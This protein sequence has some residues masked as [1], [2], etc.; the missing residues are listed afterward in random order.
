[1]L[2]ARVTENAIIATTT[3]TTATYSQCVSIGDQECQANG[4]IGSQIQALE[5]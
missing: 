4:N 5:R 1:M 3:T 2:A